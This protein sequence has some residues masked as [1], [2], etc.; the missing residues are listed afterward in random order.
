MRFKRRKTDREM[1]LF[2]I[3]VLERNIVN[4]VFRSR[5]HG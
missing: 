3:A 1:R 4:V 5:S 2:R